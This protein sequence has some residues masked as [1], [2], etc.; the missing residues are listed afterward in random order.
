MTGRE[1]LLYLINGL[2]EGEYETSVFCNEFSRTFDLEMNYE[3]LNEEEMKELSDLSEMAGRFSDDEN[4]L[5]ML[6]VY[7]DEADIIEKVKYIRENISSL[8]SK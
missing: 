7:F 5:K 3:E 8:Y 4:D 1:K 6:C 2:L